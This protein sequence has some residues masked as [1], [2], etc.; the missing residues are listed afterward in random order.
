[1]S[2]FLVQNCKFDGECYANS[3]YWSNSDPI[4]AV[5]SFSVDEQDRETHQVIF[6]NNEVC[7]DILENCLCTR[8]STDK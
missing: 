6:I 3:L 7:F 4:A 1:M 2:V 8:F 5:A